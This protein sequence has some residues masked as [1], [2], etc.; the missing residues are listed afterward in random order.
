MEQRNPRLR[1]LVVWVLAVVWMAV[2]AARLSYL[3]L[4]CYSEYLA[5]AQHQ[6]QR[7]FEIS[8][9]RGTIYDRK[10]REL[11][12]SLPMDSVFGD[13][14]EI[15]D[16][17]LVARL[18]SRSLDASAEDLET[19]IRAAHTPVRLARKLSPDVVQRISDMNLKGVFFQKENRR[20][21]PQRELA[22]SVLGY[23][24]VDEKGI[25]GIE[26]SLDSQIRGRPGRMMVIADG[27]RRWYDR[28]E[29]AADPGA[30][31]VLSIDE[32]I[33]YIAEKEL[34]RA[35]DETHAKAGTVVVQDPNSGEL[36]AVANWPVFDP[37]DAGS[38]PAE[39]RMDRAVSAAYEPGSTFKV[40]TL[41][42]AIENGVV[43]PNELVDCQMGQILVAGRLI[44]D[45]KPFGALSVRGILTNSS[46][47]GAI[48]VALRLG[49]PK[50]Y[51]TSRA[52][53][54]GQ[55]TGIEL[56]GE[57]RGLLRPI[58][59]WSASSIGSLAMGQEV[60]VTPIQIV[61][62]ISAI[63]NGGTLYRPH[64]VREIRDEPPGAQLPQPG[65]EP[66]QAT[67]A[68]TAA[69]MRQMMED[70]VLDGTGKPARLDGYTAAGKS[71]TAQKIDPATGRY[72]A[73]QYNA[74][75][76]GF[77]PVNNPVVTILVVLDSPIGPHHGG[78]VGGPVFKRIAE[79]IMAYL[80][81][82][83]DVPSP[84]DTE[85]AQ[86][87]RSAPRPGPATGDSEAARASFQAAVAKRTE[88]NAPTVAFAGQ[89][90]VAVPDLS[91]QT[92]RGVTEECSRLGL[93]PSLIG[94]G[95]AL[96]QFP[97]A[98]TQVLRG[99]RVMVRFGRPGEIQPVSSRG[100]GN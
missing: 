66:Q 28:R 59:N 33:Q 86:D 17:E 82:P 37:N 8:P 14:A 47:V 77:A 39:A 45:W 85:T 87:L 64:I 40:I 6:Q 23:V 54:I 27:R 100:N 46:D 63:A 38:Y 71:G 75:F 15:S 78:Q 53:G 35:I 83:H 67:D 61:S 32:T 90:A 41:T 26:Y 56:P 91:G 94:S 73:T 9:K 4:F 20:V 18:L 25:G 99:S 12:V 96:E 49:A 34:A 51:D 30:S 89:D 11:A 19:K 60:S 42:G 72:S 31:V 92:V 68:R 21:Y 2:V 13:P 43:T 1:W 97:G 70:V 58:E 57:N 88:P 79:Q 5:K 81:V 84:S 93:V 95:V 76:V 52:F 62:A 74:S 65:A 10:G 24:D 29:S 55:T 98:G 3:Q 16:V 22:A 44:H 80:S 69:A 36:L 48:K 7:I 50:F